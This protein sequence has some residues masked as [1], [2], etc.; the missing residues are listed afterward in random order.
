MPAIKSEW[1]LYTA[2]IILLILILA[3]FSN[4]TPN[5]YRK[6][7][8]FDYNGTTPPDRSVVRKQAESA[9]LG[10]PSGVYAKQ[11]KAAVANARVRV[12][13]WLASRG[14]DDAGESIEDFQKTYDIIFNS[15]ASEGNNHVM[16]SLI[17][18][19]GEESPRS[20]IVI[21]STEHK[22]SIDCAKRLHEL[23]LADVTFVDPAGDGRL[24]PASIGAA[25]NERTVLVTVMHYNNE[26]G[27]INDIATIGRGVRT[28]S[29]LQNRRIVFHVDAVQSFGKT[30]IPMTALGIDALT[31][32]FHKIYGPAGLGALIVRSDITLNSQVTG[33][34]NGGLRGGTENTAAIASVPETMKVMTHA[35]ASKN[36]R[37]LA[38]KNYVVRTLLSH[39]A[40]VLGHY[41][42][43]YGQSD[44]FDPYEGSDRARYELIF[45][46]PTTSDGL[47]D[48]SAAAPNTL[49]M[50]VVKR[51]PL[52]EHFCNIVLRDTLFEKHKVIVSIGS[53][54]SASAGGGSHVLT[55]LKAPYIIRCGVVRISFGDPTTWGQ[56]RTLCSALI[57]S[58]TAQ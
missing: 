58:I 30:P 22:T 33:S 3:H 36:A 45:M 57:S 47:P 52:S 7:T 28:V 55:A 56:V 24:D 53:A 1:V 15:G 4:T 6:Y 2:V 35:R 29:T 38:Y 54:C 41:S 14:T 34:Q 32:S 5:I 44:D 43:Y 23:G 31:M 11:A 25:I 50:A 40:F 12:A 9:W 10:N 46:G 27:A 42:Q 17:E 18:M 16:R 37:M 39:P 8:Y 51:A 13:A 48:S 49:Y 21:S 20:H 19:T 26:T